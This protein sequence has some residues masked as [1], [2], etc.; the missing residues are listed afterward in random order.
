L[1]AER[2]RFGADVVLGPLS[3]FVTAGAQAAA[4]I[5][6]FLGMSVH[7]VL[8]RDR[9]AADAIR[10]W[11]N[12]TNPGPLLLLPLDAVSTSAP[13]DSGDL[14]EQLE[15]APLA[16]GWARILLERVR[17]L[18]DGSFVDKRGAVWLPGPSAGPGP[19]RRRAELATL[20]TELE[21]AST[22][23]EAALAATEEARASLQ[24]AEAAVVAAADASHAAHN[25]ERQTREALSELE[26]RHARYQR[27]LG[28]SRSQSAQLSQRTDV[29]EASLKSL[30]ESQASAQTE[31]AGFDARAHEQRE[32]LVSAETRL[33]AARDRRSEGQ[34]VMA[35]A[36]ARLQVAVDRR[37]RLTEERGVA[38]G[39]LTTLAS[40][41]TLIEEADRALVPH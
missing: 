37:L 29:L 12:E 23:R 32:T 38:A 36:E 1:L 24:N 7:A 28:E 10:E 27:E 33:E 41:L 26:R 17:S 35:Q 3:D 34:V 18:D 2:D 14:V 22:A 20:R 15:V 4:S 5:E 9:A 31:A 11:H 21:N 6:R 25:I 40:E 16:V 39:R 19:L 8:V 30:D 13:V